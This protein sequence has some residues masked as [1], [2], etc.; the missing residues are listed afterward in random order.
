MRFRGAMQIGRATDT[1]VFYGTAPVSQN[2]SF[3]AGASTAA[4]I[5]TELTRLGI[6][7]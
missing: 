5:I 1:V 6:V 2:T 3:V 4:H 7:S